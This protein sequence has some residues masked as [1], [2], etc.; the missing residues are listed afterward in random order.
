MNHNKSRHINL[1]QAGLVQPAQRGSALIT[2]LVFLVVLT[3][4]GLSASS[5]SI[6]RELIAR[7]IRD[8]NVAMQA[9]DAALQGAENW[10]R[11][12]ATTNLVPLSVDPNGTAA[13]LEYGSCVTACE[14][15]T[16]SWWSTNGV[17][18]GSGPNQTKNFPGVSAAPAYF[19]EYLVPPR[20]SMT[21][22]GQQAR[23]LYYRITARGTGL[24]ANTVRIVRSIY[25]R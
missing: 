3:L 12:N 14:A 7:N 13:I 5:G 4:L 11:L 24:S 17:V 16:A 22:N 2:G 8:Q 15:G 21:F 1:V 20:S 10:I 25:R 9:A 19:I 23:P 6:Q 18:L